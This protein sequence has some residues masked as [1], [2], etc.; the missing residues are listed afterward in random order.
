MGFYCGYLLGLRWSDWGPA[1]DRTDYDIRIYDDA[2]LT[3]LEG[4][5]LDE[6]QNGAP[7][8]EHP[9]PDCDGG[10]TDVDYPHDLIASRPDQEQPGTCSSS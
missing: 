1:A 2:N 10:I 8:L 9:I 3:V 4:S 7:P 6:Q 5:G